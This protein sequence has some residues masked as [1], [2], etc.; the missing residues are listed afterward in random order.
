MGE[1]LTNSGTSSCIASRS[2][3]SALLAT[4]YL[5]QQKQGLDKGDVLLAHQSHSDN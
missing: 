4:P 5:Q 2:L 3:A 1:S